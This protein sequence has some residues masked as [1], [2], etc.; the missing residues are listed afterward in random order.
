M[1]NISDHYLIIHNIAKQ[2]IGEHNLIY[3]HPF[4]STQPE[5]FEHLRYGNGIYKNLL[6]CYD[7]EPLVINYNDIIFEAAKL[8]TNNNTNLILINTEKNSTNKKHFIRK[9]GYK[10]CY[11]FFHGLAATDWYRSYYY[12]TDLIDPSTRKIVK[13]FITFN[14][15]TGNARCYRSFFVSELQKNNI[16]NF[17]HV[18]YSKHCPIFGHYSQNMFYPVNQYGVSEHYV[19]KS[20]QILDSIKENLVID[21]TNE[22]PNTSFE[23]SAIPQMME[24]F[25]HVVTETCFWD[26]KEHLTEKIF[27]PI[28]ARQPFVLLG[29]QGNLNYLR[30]YGFKTFDKWWDESY[31]VINDPIARIQAVIKILN[32]ICNLDNSKLEKILVEMKETLEYNYNLFYSR[33]F[34][35]SILNEFKANLL[36]TNDMF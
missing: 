32:D 27:K 16:L 30:S 33:N 19:K 31:D 26:E 5:N 21:Y 36:R 18:S 1:Y 2:V 11:Y 15:L 13:K 3:L 6:L 9:Y 35:D 24:S 10:D 34:V 25:L 4:G 29:C 28:V 8:F 14:R 17:G 22:I 23:I 7:Q 20:I 12:N